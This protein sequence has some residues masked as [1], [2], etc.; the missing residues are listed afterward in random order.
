MDG[1]TANV[2]A[3]SEMLTETRKLRQE[4]SKCHAETKTSLNRL[5]ASVT[6]IKQRMDM[7]DKR[8][9]TAEQRKPSPHFS[10]LEEPF[11]LLNPLT[12]AEVRPLITTTA[13]D[14]LNDVM[15]TKRFEHFSA[16]STLM[17]AVARLI[18]IARSFF[19][20]TPDN[21]CQGWH[22]FRAGPTEEE[23]EKAKIFVIKSVQQECFLKELNCIA[24]VSHWFSKKS[25][26]SRLQ[27]HLLNHVFNCL[28]NRW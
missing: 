10:E 6:E 25:N 17:T 21:A 27:L 20:S 12:D 1:A 7:L 18:H 14:V 15:S 22:I 13:K 4:N 9:T 8:V 5:E 24:R 28:D 2:N 23:L 26:K 16:W 3:E 19:N 11:D